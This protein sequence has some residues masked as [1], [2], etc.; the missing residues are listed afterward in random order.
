MCPPEPSD[1]W[2]WSTAALPAPVNVSRRKAQHSS[3]FNLV[4]DQ[5]ISEVAYELA[6]ASYLWGD[7]PGQDSLYK[8]GLLT[9]AELETSTLSALYSR[10]CAF[11]KHFQ[12]ESLGLGCIC[13]SETIGFLKPWSSEKSAIW[14]FSAFMDLFS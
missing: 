5:F 7:L 4:I 2:G 1:G 3:I 14:L 10:L 8:V 6:N 13:I 9:A 12:T 11:S